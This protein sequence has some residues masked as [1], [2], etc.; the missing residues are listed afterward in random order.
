MKKRGGKGREGKRGG[1]GKGKGKGEE[2]KRKK[3]KGK[4]LLCGETPL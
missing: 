3:S 1:K 4:D 2:R